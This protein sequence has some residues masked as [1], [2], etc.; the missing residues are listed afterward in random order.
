[1]WSI[2]ENQCFPPSFM[3]PQETFEQLQPIHVSERPKT[4]L[5]KEDFRN[6]HVQAVL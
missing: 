2:C 4:L 6:E 3:L 1:M 5:A